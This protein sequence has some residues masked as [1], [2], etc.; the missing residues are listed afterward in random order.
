M[1]STRR[2][3]LAGSLGVT[4]ALATAGCIDDSPGTE[5]ESPTDSPQGSPSETETP[6]PES[7]ERSVG[8]DTVAVTDIVAEKAVSYESLM[9]A[10]GVVAPEGRQFVV[11]SVRSDAELEMDQFSLQAGGEPWAAVDPGEH[12]ARNYSVA[13]HE[14]GVVGEPAA[15][16]DGSKRYVAFELDSPLSAAD[17]RIV[18]ERGGESGEW[19]LPDATQETL[20]ASSPSFERDSLSVPDSV[21]QGEPLEVELT[22]TNTSDTDGRFLAAVYWPTRLIA[23][24]DESHLIESSVAAGESTT[25]SLSLDTEYTTDT[26]RTV[27]LRV[28]GHVDAEREVAFEARTATP[29]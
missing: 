15:S 5:S 21:Q 8:G 22:A 28:E 18:L 4:A 6:P 19:A 9:G 13:D 23:D 24:D 12:G 2:Q 29:E 27:T 16:G 20:A 3:F 1:P 10:G 26:S 11:A 17:P 25:A 7:A 14:G